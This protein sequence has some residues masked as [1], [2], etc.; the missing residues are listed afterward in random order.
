MRRLLTVMILS[1]VLVQPVRAVDPATLMLDRMWDFMQWFLAQTDP[2][3]DGYPRYLPHRGPATMP[4]WVAQWGSPQVLDGVWQ[5]ASGEYWMVKG[6][7]FVLLTRGGRR[8]DG[9]FRREGPFIIAQLPDGEVEFAY[10]LRG[11][12]LQLRDPNGRGMTL[13]R[14]WRPGWGW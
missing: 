5:A 11:D 9:G 4:P 8:F 14:L 12:L 1:M 3:P 2:L 13:R 10:R 6:E 7:R